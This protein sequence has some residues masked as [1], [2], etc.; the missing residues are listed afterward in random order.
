MLK[1]L[2]GAKSL[3]DAEVDVELTS[4]IDQIFE[5]ADKDKS[6]TLTLDEVPSVLFFQIHMHPQVLTSVSRYPYLMSKFCI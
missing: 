4:I 2:S 6:G 5:V 1:G 3:S